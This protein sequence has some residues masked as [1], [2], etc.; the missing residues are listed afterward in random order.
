[1]STSITILSGYIGSDTEQKGSAYT[2]SIATDESY[3]NKEGEK[4]EKSQWHRCV[5]YGKLG[6]FAMG[7]VKKGVQVTVIGK[8]E[9]S[10]YEKSDYPG[11]KFYSTSV[12]V[13]EINMITWPEQAGASD[14]QS[15]DS[16]APAVD[17][18]DIPF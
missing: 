10:S 15:G 4:V 16:E 6:E 2:F 12:I 14:L 13:R 7:F 11:A 9:T 3:K 1:M 8:N 17:E 5:A 18:D